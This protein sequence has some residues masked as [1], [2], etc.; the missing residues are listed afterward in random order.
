VW[1]IETDN[2]DGSGV[3]SVG[4]GI[5]TT[6]MK[7]R[8]TYNL[9]GW[10]F[11][12]IWG[13]NG[14]DND[15]YPFLRFQGFTHDSSYTAP[16]TSTPTVPSGGGGGGGGSKTKKEIATT[17]TI[18]SQQPVEVKATTPIV[19]N[20]V[21]DFILKNRTIF[22][23]AIKAGLVLPSF[24]NDILAV[25]NATVVELGVIVRDLTSGM[26]GDDVMALQKL[27]INEGYSLPAG[28]TGFFGSQTKDAL[29]AYQTKAG[30]TPS[31]GYFGLKTRA[32]MKNA[33]LSGL[34]W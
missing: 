19:N 32:H 1:D 13:M 20:Q 21:R 31:Q 8:L 33:G 30:L 27:L 25:P 14:T 9:L 24:I 18:T 16:A 5:S 34:W 29:I 12:S 11:S 4:I 7:T 6:E 22:E 3:G 17:T 28:A 2:V 26:S 10:N 15:S 23:A